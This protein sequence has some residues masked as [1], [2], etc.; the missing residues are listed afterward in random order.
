M[1][2]VLSGK[3]PAFRSGFLLL[4]TAGFRSGT[5]FSEG[6]RKNG[7]GERGP[8]LMWPEGWESQ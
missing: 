6:P 2:A 5:G 1:G 4:E 3:D 7:F 8:R